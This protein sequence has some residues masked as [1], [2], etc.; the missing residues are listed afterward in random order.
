[1]ND[2]ASRSRIEE[3]DSFTYFNDEKWTLE[4][5]TIFLQGSSSLI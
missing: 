5:R 4:E 1:M 3:E 2:N